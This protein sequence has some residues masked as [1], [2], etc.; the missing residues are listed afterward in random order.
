MCIGGRGRSPIE[1]FWRKTTRKDM[2][3]AKAAKAG[4][5]REG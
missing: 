5:L 2:I 3:E 1:K 4:A